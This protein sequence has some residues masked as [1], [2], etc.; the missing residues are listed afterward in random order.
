MPV[1]E[2]VR[3]L[4]ADWLWWLL[5]PLLDQVPHIALQRGELVPFSLPL[6]LLNRPSPEPP[7]SSALPFVELPL[8]L[9]IA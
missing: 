6:P 8:V 5:A 3:G 9:A 2:L 1:A 7:S 4:P